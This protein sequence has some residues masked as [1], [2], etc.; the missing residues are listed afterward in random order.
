MIETDALLLI[1]VY[2]GANG[3][4]IYEIRFIPVLFAIQ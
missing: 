3:H 2:T 4:N 1:W